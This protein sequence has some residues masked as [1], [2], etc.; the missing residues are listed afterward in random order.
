MAIVHLDG[1]EHGVFSVTGEGLYDTVSGTPVTETTLIPP[2]S[3]GGRSMKCPATST[4]DYV[5][6]NIAG[7]PAVVVEQFR[8]MVPGTMVT[9]IPV[10]LANLQGNGGI[11]VS[12]TITSTTTNQLLLRLHDT[13]TSSDSTAFTYIDDTWHLLTLLLNLTTS[14]WTADWSVDGVAQGQA[15]LVTSGAGSIITAQLGPDITGA[16]RTTYFDDW[17][18]ATG[19]AGD[20]PMDYVVKGY[21]PD[22]RGTHNL[23]ASTSQFFFKYAGSDVAL[24]TTET[25]AHT[26]IDDVP[27]SAGSDYLLVKPFDPGSGTQTDLLPTAVEASSNYTSIPI[28]NIDED[29][30]SPDGSWGTASGNNVPT[31]VRVSFPTPT[32]SPA[33]SGTLT[34][35]V[36]VRKGPSGSAGSGTPTARI[37][38]YN[39]GSLVA[40]GSAQNVT[41]TTGQKLTQDFD[42]AT[43]NGSGQLGNG[44]GLE[45]LIAGTQ[46]GGGPSARATVEVGAVDIQSL[47]YGGTT[48]PTNT[49]YAEHT[50]AD[51]SEATD[52]VAVRVAVALSNSFAAANSVTVNLRANGVDGTVFSGD[53]AFSVLVYKTGVFATAPGGAAWTDAI[54]DGATIRWGYTNDAT[55]NPRLNAAIVEAAFPTPAAP[56][57]FPGYKRHRMHLQ[58]VTR[59]A[60]R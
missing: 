59:A 1:F 44:S 13:T 54:F 17:V 56:P 20:Y 40:S 32:G 11:G 50:I 2:I 38:L 53:P 29:P 46:S 51:S 47:P 27:I 39:N 5:I 23:D 7:S 25:D 9:G 34:V 3:G 18:I 48:E 45:V 49:W 52:P 16:N 30:D 31:S 57:P 14:T 8:F 4:E 10:G 28:A 24:T 33:T 55:P 36:Y 43:V 41:S 60:V 12:V 26:Y 42:L 6:K 15:Q 58:A 37:D 35:A 21:S 22:G 19:S